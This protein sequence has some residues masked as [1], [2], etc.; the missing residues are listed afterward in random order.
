MQEPLE[1]NAENFKAVTALSIA[2]YIMVLY[3][4]DEMK[5][6]RIQKDIDKMSYDLTHGKDD[7][8]KL[9]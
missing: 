8:G 1:F 3:A 6:R 7:D 2:G 9:D 5:R 4:R